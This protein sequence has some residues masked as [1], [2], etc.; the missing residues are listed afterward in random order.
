MENLRELLYSKQHRQA[1]DICAALESE[2]EESDALYADL[3]LFLEMLGSDSAYV[4]VRGF[5]LICAQAKWDSGNLLDRHLNRILQAL[6]DDKPTNLRQYLSVLPKLLA[7]KPELREPVREKLISLDP[8]R[9]RDTMA[10]LIAKD[11]RAVLDELEN[12]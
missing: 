10:P 11:I 8:T 6:E 3:P 2:S 5:R 7:A 4:R 12:R 9:Y 1:Q